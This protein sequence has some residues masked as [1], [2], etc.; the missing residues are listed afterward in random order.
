VHPVDAQRDRRDGKGA[1]WASGVTAVTLDRVTIAIGGN[2]ILADVSL[3]VAE[4][5]FIGVL[6]ANGAGKTTLMKAILGLIAPSAG[7][8]SVLGQPATRGNRK[9]GYMPQMRAAPPALR[10]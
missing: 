8:I 2:T 5:E 9:I 4:G 3:G 7:R 1:R 6:G 10:L